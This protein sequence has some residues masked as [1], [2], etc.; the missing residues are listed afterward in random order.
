MVIRGDEVH[1]LPGGR[2][3]TGETLAETIEREVWEEAGWQV[4]VGTVVG[5][6]QFVHLGPRPPG[7]VQVVYRDVAQRRVPEARL[8]GDYEVEG[9]FLPVSEV[10]VGDTLPVGSV[11]LE[12]ALE[13]RF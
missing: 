11:F 9:R 13:R 2:R 6:I 1:V 8:P 4:E 12:A 10:R 3:E 5:F 7:F